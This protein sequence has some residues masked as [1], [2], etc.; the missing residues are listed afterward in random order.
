[1]KPNFDSI[2]V[3]VEDVTSLI[4]YHLCPRYCPVLLNIFPKFYIIEKGLFFEAR[5][6]FA[7]FCNK[8]IL[9]LGKPHELTLK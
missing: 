9:G 2:N 4:N 8:Q 5:P 1:M 3:T 7:K 6:Y